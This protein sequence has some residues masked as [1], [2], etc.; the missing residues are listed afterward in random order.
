MRDICT[1]GGDKRSMEREEIFEN[2]ARAVIEGDEEKCKEYAKEVLRD[3]VDPLK[4]IEKGLSKGMISL[5]ERFERGEVFLPDLLIAADAFNIAIEVLK[6]AMEAQKKQAAKVATV[7]IGTVNG[8]V[9]GIGKNIVAVV[10]GAYGFEVIDIGVDNPS[11]KFIEEA[12]KVRADLIGL[13][14]LMTTTMPAQK[15]VIEILKEMRLR[16]KYLVVVGGGPVTQEWANKIG[17][18]GYARS[19]FQAVDMIKELLSQRRIVD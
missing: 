12:E 9:H 11:L 16:D 5:G 7:L 10:L 2:L 3:K 13:S 14:S 18:D 17:A 19:A 8:D 4:A 6:P 1:C 15:E